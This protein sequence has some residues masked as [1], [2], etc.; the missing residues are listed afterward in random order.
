MC[1]GIVGLGAAVGAASDSARQ[2]AVQNAED[3]ANSRVDDRVVGQEQRAG[4]YRRAIAACL[5]GR[6]YTV[7]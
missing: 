6:G 5:E 7:R 1:S 2:Q 4:A 3:R